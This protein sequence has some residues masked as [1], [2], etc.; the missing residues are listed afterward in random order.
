MAGNTGLWAWTKESPA[1]K[2]PTPYGFYEGHD[3]RLAEMDTLWSVGR[4]PREAIQAICAARGWGKASKFTRLPK[5]DER[6]TWG[7]HFVADNGTSFKA[8]GIHIPGG[9]ILTWWK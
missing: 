5:G 6:Y 9:V 8:A 4:Y 3:P 1:S 2:K 7:F